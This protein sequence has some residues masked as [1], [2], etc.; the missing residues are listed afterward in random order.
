[1]TVSPQAST[2][3]TATLTDANGCSFVEEFNV[4]LHPQPD[5]NFEFS[6]GPE[7]DVFNTKVEFTNTTVYGANLDWEWYIADLATFTTRDAY[8]EFPTK[9]GKKFVNC[10]KAENEQGCRDSICKVLYI[11]YEV[12]LFVPNTFTPNNDDI[13]D[14]LYPEVEGLKEEGYKFYI[15]NRWGELLFSTTNQLEGWDGT[16]QGKKVIEGSYIWRVKGITKQTDEDF[17]KIGHTTILQKL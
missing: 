16:Y 3:Y 15:F 2:T 9:G 1:M 8:L 13:N 4:N 6:P 5:V 11:K 10:L 14:V 12:L 17:E 7:T